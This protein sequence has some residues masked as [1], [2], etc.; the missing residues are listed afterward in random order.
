MKL[1]IILAEM[2]KDC[3]PLVSRMPNERAED[4]MSPKEPDQPKL[5]EPKAEMNDLKL[6][7]ISMDGEDLERQTKAVI[8]ERKELSGNKESHLF[9]AIRSKLATQVN[10]V[11]ICLS[12][13][14]S[15]RRGDGPSDAL[16][17]LANLSSMMPTE[18]GDGSFCS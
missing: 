2:Q 10:G 8:G 14:Q 16:Q 13:V 1:A 17:T 11:K 15:Q 12:S 9:G 7:A 4:V 3:S 6:S 5:Q 18:N